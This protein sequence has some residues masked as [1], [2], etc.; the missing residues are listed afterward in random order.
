MVA[1]GRIAKLNSF[2]M[3]R[4]RRLAF[5]AFSVV[6]VEDSAAVFQA[7]EVDPAAGISLYLAD[8]F[9]NCS[10]CGLPF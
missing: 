2:V 10:V 8:S 1:G 5:M 9:P 6:I 7:R 4:N 3:Q